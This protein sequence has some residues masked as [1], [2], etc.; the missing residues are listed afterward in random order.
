MPANKEGK[1]IRKAEVARLKMQGKTCRE[2][3]EETGIDKSAV[4]RDWKE[5]RQDETLAE[6]LEALKMINLMNSLDA[7][8]AEGKFIQDRL[9]R[10]EITSD[11]MAKI[12]AAKLAGQKVYSFLAG[13]NAND[14]G[15]EKDY[16]RYSDEQLRDILNDKKN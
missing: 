9:S 10:K 3:E 2:I 11:E 15:G 13:E 7:S 12:T 14:K 1:E 4:S 16:S 6:T 8:T 5:L